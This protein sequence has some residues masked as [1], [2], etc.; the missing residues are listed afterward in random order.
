VVNTPHLAALV[1]PNPPVRLNPAELARLGVPIGGQV[2]LTSSR[3]S[4]VFPVEA[5][6]GL[7]KGAVGLTFNLGSPGASD[8]IDATADVT[9]VRVETT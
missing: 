5:D 1:A 3:T 6:P 4:L 2:R 8:L 9:E 7:P